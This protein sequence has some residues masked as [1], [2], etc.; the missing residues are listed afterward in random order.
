MSK[1]S[2]PQMLNPSD[3]VSW[4]SCIRRVWLDKKEKYKGVEAEDKFQEL[5]TK[6]GLDHEELVRQGL[7]KS[8]TVREANSLENTQALMDAGVDVIYQAQLVDPES[9]IEGRPDFLIRN[10]SGQYQAADAKLSLTADKKAIQAQLGLYR[11]ILGSGLPAI[12]YLGNGQEESVSE[13]ADQVASEFVADMRKILANDHQ[14]RVRYSHSKCRMCPYYKHCSDAFID[15][16]ELSLLYGIQGRAAD[17]L[18]EVGISTISQLAAFDP[19]DIPDVPYLKEYEKKK[20]AVL[21]A[22]SWLTGEVYP[23][24]EVS[25]PDGYWVH[26]DIEDNPLTGNGE[27]HVYLWGFLIP[28]YRNDNFEYVWTD[29]AS[30]DEQGWL[31]FLEKIKKYRAEHRNLVVAHYSSHERSTISSYASR[32]GMEDNETV[33]YLLG[34]NSPLFDMQKPVLEKFVLPLQGYG[35]KD[36]CKH[37]DLVNFQ[38]E[39]DESGSQWSVVQFHRF[40]HEPDP[41]VKSR[42]KSDILGYNRDDVIATRRLEEWLRDV[43]FK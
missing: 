30:E 33:Q 4:A 14:P 43:G 41:L 24:G 42:L 6:L 20:R 34:E 27:R 26:F 15:E 16:E 10:E 28:D 3:A 31:L 25:L 39:D 40:L 17:G 1:I 22:K 18:E 9:G 19:E 7:S 2:S 5:V 32:Y 21:Q 37:K 11:R 35:L 29:D 13:K 38:W 23:L 12:V 8:F 36:I